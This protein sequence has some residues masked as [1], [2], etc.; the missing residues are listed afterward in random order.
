MSRYEKSVVDAFFDHRK[1]TGAP[2]QFSLQVVTDVY[3]M[4]ARTPKR[5]V[6]GL[7]ESAAWWLV[8]HLPCK[9]KAI[10]DHCGRPEHR[11]CVWCFELMP[12]AEVKR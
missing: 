12:N 7:I 10:D 6:L 3:G 2:W 5:Q 9:H 4:E 8:G 11:H 1:R